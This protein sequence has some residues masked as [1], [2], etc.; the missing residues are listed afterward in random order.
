MVRQ[1]GITRM[2]NVTTP[3]PA[4]GF[5]LTAITL[6]ASL[7]A[8]AGHALAQDAPDRFDW[9]GA[10]AGVHL[11]GAKGEAGASTRLDVAANETSDFI[12]TGLGNID[13][14]GSSDFESTRFTGGLQAGYNWQ[15]G[16]WVIGLESDIA[17]LR[18]DASNGTGPQ[19]FPGLQNGAERYT[20][21]RTVETDWLLTVRPRIGYST[22]NL[23][24]FGTA[25]L[26]VTKVDAAF[27]YAD[28]ISGFQS[29][30]SASGTASKT[31]AGWT[32]GAG[33]EAALSSNWI[34]KADYLFANFDRGA[35]SITSN[36]LRFDGQN[37]DSQLRQDT[38]LHFHIGRI[39]LNYKF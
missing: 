25:G 11:G 30:G 27:T 35:P 3:R 26:A 7:L 22:G 34:V 9:S 33:I 29:S 36:N 15:F 38:D 19:L 14:F 17:W 4:A 10:Y 12:E 28:N 23:L 5:G 39:G 24:V 20:I 1:K 2:E 37:I 32:I 31:V 16:N 6:A 13:S 18:A 8:G 21:A